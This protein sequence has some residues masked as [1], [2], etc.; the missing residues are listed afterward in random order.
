LRDLR[1]PAPVLTAAAQRL[2]MPGT[3]RTASTGAQTGRSPAT[4]G[5]A[6]PP[7][8]W[9][10]TVAGRRVSAR[11]L[12]TLLYMLANDYD[13]LG[14]TQRTRECRRWARSLPL[15]TA[16]PLLPAW[17]RGALDR[18]VASQGNAR[19]TPGRGSSGLQGWRR[20]QV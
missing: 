19:S 11:R 13:R 9:T 8:L 16:E 14:E 2:I 3:G 10:A 12:R 20:P 18:A 6:Q 17:M 1:R 5:G 7:A 15:C 4:S